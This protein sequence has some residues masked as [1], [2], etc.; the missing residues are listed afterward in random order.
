MRVFL[1]GATGFIGSHLASLLAREGCEVLALVRPGAD[2][3]RLAACGDAVRWVEGDLIDPDSFRG[4]VV[5]F[6]PEFC[7]HLAWYAVPG[8]YPH[9]PVNLDC[10]A[11]SLKLLEILDAADCPRVLV[12]GTCFEYDTD[13]GYLS[14]ETVAA[15]RNLYAAAK[16]AL[17]LTARQYQRLHG[18]S[19]CWA[20][21]FYQYGPWEDERRLVPAM[22]RRLLAGEPCPL[23]HGEQVRDFLHV[24]DVAAALW[25]A[26][27]SGIDGPVNIGSSRPVTV[28]GIAEEVA[29]IIGRPDLLRFGAIEP[30]A[31][32][33]RFVC[34]DTRRLREA[35]G[36]SPSHSLPDGLRRAVDWWRAAAG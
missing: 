34:A 18:R 28:R 11:A 32:D 25:A 5:A 27:L 17:F 15:P 9:S 4:P 2:R 30:P 24:E 8:K 29:A 36:W 20:R 13:Y 12:A 14:E 21:I 1:T 35:T 22:I 33:P 7:A 31:G 16:H 6:R 19:L 3:S 23:T 10:L 26:G